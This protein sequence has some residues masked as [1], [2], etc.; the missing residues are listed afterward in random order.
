VRAL[1]A[2]ALILVAGPQAVK[3]CPYVPTASN[4]PDIQKFTDGMNAQYQSHNIPVRA[5]S[6]SFKFRG[7][8]SDR[9]TPS[10]R[11]ECQLE[12]VEELIAVLKDRDFR[13][14]SDRELR[15]SDLSFDS[16][17]KM[18][19]DTVNKNTPF[20]LRGQMEELDFDFLI[21]LTENVA[22]A[23]RGGAIAT[24]LVISKPSQR[25]YEDFGSIAAFVAGIG[26]CSSRGS[27]EGSFVRYTIN[28]IEDAIGYSGE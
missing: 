3:A 6:V 15:A 5:K 18:M 7:D 21:F 24:Y 13:R 1:F 12:V 16:M 8:S 28:D 20:G 10:S 4:D 25:D 2:L 17:K 22:C 9:P 27:L 23:S 19:R 14:V 11:E 26:S